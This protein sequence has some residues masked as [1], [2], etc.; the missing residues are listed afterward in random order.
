MATAFANPAD[1]ASTRLWPRYHVRLPVLIGARN[2]DSKI[3]VP[4]LACEI[5]QRGMALYG[6]VNLE[7]GDLMEIEFQTWG[8]LRVAGVVRNRSGFCFGLE[9]LEL[10]TSSEAANVLQPV[11][12]ES[13]DPKWKTW[14]SEHRG[15]AAIALATLLFVFALSGW[16][17]PPAQR[18]FVASNASSQPSLTLAERMLVHLGLAEVPPAP[19]AEGNPHVQVWVDIHTGLYYCPGADLYGKTRDGKFTTQR[20]AQLDQFEPA[21]RKNCE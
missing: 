16:L 1:P 2:N 17:S 21:A 7:P 10:M 20:D 3:A 9:F 4:G 18:D 19:V 14:W 12:R 13:Q 11:G 15:D 8:K 5:S 6:G